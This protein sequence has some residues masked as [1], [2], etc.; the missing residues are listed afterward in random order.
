MA[1]NLTDNIFK[2][3]FLNENDRTRYVYGTPTSEVTP[4]TVSIPK[5]YT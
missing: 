1:A 5:V 2:C 4:V 3:G